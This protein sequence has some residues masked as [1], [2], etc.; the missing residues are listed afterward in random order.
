MLKILAGLAL[1][2]ICLSFFQTQDFK[3][4][5]TDKKLSINES[6]A[7]YEAPKAQHRSKEPQL[8]W[9]SD[10]VKYWSYEDTPIQAQKWDSL[11]LKNFAAIK[12][13]SKQD[14]TPQTFDLFVYPSVESKALHT[15][16][17]RAAHFDKGAVHLVSNAYFKG[18][19][20]AHQY[21]PLLAQ[22]LDTQEQ[23]A[24]SVGLAMQWADSLRQKPWSHWVNLLYAADALPPLKDLYNNIAYDKLSPIIAHLSAA[25]WVAFAIEQWGLEAFLAHYQN[26]QVSEQELRQWQDQWYEWIQHNAPLSISDMPATPK[27][28]LNGFTFAHEGYRIYNGYGGELA[29]T[30]LERLKQLKINALAI[31]PY[32]YMRS[33]HKAS[34]IPIVR[35]AGAENDESVLFAHYTSKALG[36]Y[37]MLKPQI[38][39]HS[40]WPGAIE[41][42]DKAAWQLFFDSYRKWIMHYALL[43]EMNGF[44]ALCIGTEFKQITLQHPKY[45]KQL[46]ADIRTIFHGAL[47]YAANWGE[48][49]ENITF[50]EDLDFIGINCY[51]P[52]SSK[53]DAT[54]E[55]LRAG[56][57]ANLAKIKGIQE[58]YQR[59]VWLTEVGF[60]S[61]TH[62][63]T[64]PHEEAGSREIDEEAQALCYEL[65]LSELEQ[66]TWITGLFCWKWPSYL[67]HNESGGRGYMPLGKQTEEVFKKY[68]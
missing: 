36:N 35:E 18:E 15:H 13:L 57:Q 4:T 17:M 53:K 34:A 8:V 2:G 61:A 23:A 24:L 52:L 40:S 39:I 44:D 1:G 56:M 42:K 66:A 48:E 9:Q 47:T 62:A 12:A 16:N 51:Y 29:K 21:R 55:E 20:W 26:P 14:V 22:V 6:P 49:C 30:S 27:E 45:W 3:D 10:H 37:N 50:W 19:D 58:K 63:W 5:N 60:R 28:R 33:A 32:S 38:W 43:A 68:F 65:L 67:Q 11:W 64:A 46:I 25:S 41:F 54:K 31:V 59:P 7:S